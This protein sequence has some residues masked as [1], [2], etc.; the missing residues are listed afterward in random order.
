MV[1]SDSGDQEQAV[2]INFRDRDLR[3]RNFSGESLCNADFSGADL[4]GCRLVATD[5]S[6][7]IFRSAVMGAELVEVFK[8]VVF[9]GFIILR[10]QLYVA[11]RVLVET[12]IGFLFVIAGLI[13]GVDK[14]LLKLDALIER[15]NQKC[16]NF[17]NYSI[18][19]FMLACFV[20]FAISAFGV[21]F[22]TT[23]N[24]AEASVKYLYFWILGWWT[25]ALGCLVGV[26]IGARNMVRTDLS[27]AC[28]D[29]AQIDRPTFQKAKTTGAAIETTI[30]L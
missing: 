11:I 14:L 6:G 9:G 17:M 8:V 7:A 18:V 10:F 23:E 29:L 12:E 2:G 22:L 21:W 26:V 27:G 19:E 1:S 16:L 5:L 15:E 13:F 20:C 4:R 25:V 28:L 3:G 30:W 24:I